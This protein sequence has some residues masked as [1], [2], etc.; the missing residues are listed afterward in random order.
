MTEAERKY[1]EILQKFSE[2]IE[3]WETIKCKLRDDIRIYQ[4]LIIAIDNLIESRQK[5][6]EKLN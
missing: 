5:K 6:F 3:R 1:N 4:D 2:D